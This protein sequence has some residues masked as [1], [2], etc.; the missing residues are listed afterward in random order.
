MRVITQR[1]LAEL[2]AEEEQAQA[3]DAQLQSLGLSLAQ[4]KIKNAQK[5]AMISS[6]GQQL[7]LLKIDVALMKGAVG[8]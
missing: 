8:K 7:A 6:L 1:P 5:D 3:K 2:R 4:E